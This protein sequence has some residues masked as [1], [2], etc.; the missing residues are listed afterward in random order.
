[1]DESR[2]LSHLR[3]LVDAQLINAASAEAFAF[4]HALTREAVYAT[5]LK[6]QRVVYH[7][8]VADV[9]EELSGRDAPL[10]ARAA[11]LAYH[12]RE[13]A[14][15]PK[16]LEYAHRAGE[17]AQSLYAPRE[18]AQHFT[19]ALA[20]G[21][22]LGQP[23]DL[24]LLRAR[25]QAYDTL[26]EFELARADYELGLR[27]A[28]ASGAAPAEWQALL[29]LGF[30]WA[31]RDYAR[32][33]EY[34]QQ[35]LE[36]ARA[37][38]DPFTVAH[39]LNRIGNW[40]T[41]TGRSPEG[42]QAHREALEIFRRQDSVLDEAAT[43]DLMG[44]AYSFAGDGLSAKAQVEQAIEQFRQAGDKRGLVSNL[45]AHC[46]LA[47]ETDIQTWTGQSEQSCRAEMVEALELAG[48]IGWLAGQALVQWTMGF[49]LSA[50]GELGEALAQAK[51]A[52][53]TAAEIEH[54]QWTIAAEF[55]LGRIYTL[56]LAPEE[57]LRHLQAAR[58]LAIELGSVWW[59]SSV[60]AVAALAHLQ[61][62]QPQVAV[63]ELQTV[64]SALGLEADWPARPPRTLT[65]RY[66]CWAWAETALAG[67][68]PL[69][70]LQAADRI[71]NSAVNPNQEP[72]PH[73]LKLKGEALAAL[74]HFAAAEIVLSQALAGA[75][76][77][78]ARPIIWQI[79]RDR[80]R[81]ARQQ[82]RADE[83][84]R[85]LA[86]ARAAIEELASTVDQ[87]EREVFRGRALGEVNGNW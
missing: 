48:Q 85:E 49:C 2:L 63:G 15:W 69:E 79:H 80:A 22:Q 10:A 29:D 50:F 73:L 17:Q 84:E 33:G 6:R 24:R 8:L 18:A 77:H 28:R 3:E 55:T 43:H 78:Q 32:T 41:N 54:R 58:P 57:A 61:L 25:G 21:R 7:A 56:L 86:A 68:Q 35:A 46:T 81:L 36:Q 64:A 12:Y 37:I 11:D 66:L 14:N 20:A 19:H 52:R 82:G 60:T 65:E 38:G 87:P 67:G 34:L 23:P 53:Q 70:A 5:L 31:G 76:A 39:S 83:A 47:S 51:A 4:R 13:A 30:L 26:G 40:L 1:M 27:L 75:Q 59:I 72:I 44:M 71:L 9:L 16:A 74:N 42:L 45:A 62:G